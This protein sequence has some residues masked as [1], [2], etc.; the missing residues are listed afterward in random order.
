MRIEPREAE[1]NGPSRREDTR[2]LTLIVGAGL[3]GVVGTAALVAGFA[4]SGEP[5]V[6]DVVR[7][8]LEARPST[9]TSIDTPAE[10]ATFEVS[11]RLY[12]RVETRSGEVHTGL[13]RWDQNEASWADMLDALKGDRT[14]GIRFGHIRTLEPTGS[15]S[16]R[17]TLR[18][19]GVVD[20]G[21]N[22]TDLGRSL[23]SLVVER[24]GADAARLD[25]NELK[26]VEFEAAP[27]ELRSSERRLH[28]TVSTLSGHHFTGYVAWNV[29]DVYTSDVLNARSGS[30]LRSVPFH[31][32]RGVESTGARSAVAVLT[33]GTRLE[34]R[35]GGDI[36]ASSGGLTVSDPGLGEVKVPW[37][38]LAAVRFHAP[39][40]PTDHGDFDGGAVLRGTVV[41]EDGATHT[42]SVLWDRDEAA[43]W[44]LLHGNTGGL[45][46]QVE[47]SAIA[48]IGKTRSGVDLELRDG[49]TFALT[50][51]NDVTRSNQ[52]I[53][54]AG[55]GR[56]TEVSWSDFAELRLEP[57]S[58]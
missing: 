18:S 34:L 58:P 55:E 47:F 48:R 10:G 17:L 14:S 39:E 38:Q 23:R 8:R 50:G 1:M 54:V 40:A 2:N 20:L 26:R 42:G 49:R 52:G 29:A 9:P 16:A 44:E 21:G 19:G 32:V 46:L 22:A 45:E 31:A 24:P 36:G 5:A 7:V 11:D 53:L 56:I 15:R 6:H 25:W 35:G 51:S 41:T 28:G 12:G 3:L 30:G 13:L 4:R 43:S 57:R 33:D 27:T 37:N